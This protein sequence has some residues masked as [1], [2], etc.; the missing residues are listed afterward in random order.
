MTLVIIILSILLIISIPAILVLVSRIVR[1]YDIIESQRI[2][3]EF[4]RN[5][6]K[7][8]DSSPEA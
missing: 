6:A 3:E 1:L 4:W 2:T 5:E 7:K 8:N